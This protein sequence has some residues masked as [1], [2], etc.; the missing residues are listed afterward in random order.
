[1]RNTLTNYACK[2]TTQ[3]SQCYICND[4][5]RWYENKINNYDNIIL[6]INDNNNVIISIIMNIII[7]IYNIVLVVRFE[8]YL[9]YF[10]Y[11]Q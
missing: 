10:L 6:I 4:N 1:M 9:K 8:N 2:T 3:P 7:I 11:N 5:G